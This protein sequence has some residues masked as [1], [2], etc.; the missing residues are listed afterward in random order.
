MAIKLYHQEHGPKDGRPIVL[1]HGFPLSSESFSRQFDDLAAA[2]FRVIA[3]DR[4]GFG[5]SEKPA[6]GFDYDS[7]TAD[8]DDLLQSLKIQD[9]TL[10][11]FSMGGGEVARYVGNYG[12]QRVRSI[13]FAA[14]VPPYLL[15]TEDNPEGPLSDEKAAE[16][17][18]LLR[19]DRESYFDKFTTLFYSAR[20]KLMVSEDER[21][22]ALELCRQSDPAAALGCMKAFSTTDFRQDLQ[23]ITVPTLVIHGDADAVVPFEGSGKRI[24]EM[25]EHSQLK[26]ISGAPHGLNVSHAAE[27]N[28]SLLAFCHQ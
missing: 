22:R 13:V 11:G 16:K 7:L 25:V 24:H 14:A 18:A 12:E 1:I 17:E 6:L 9:V 8:L 26:L 10:V 19:Q 27:F 3:Y 21:R 23:K 28:E 4:R 20:E 15:K 5:Q 2:G